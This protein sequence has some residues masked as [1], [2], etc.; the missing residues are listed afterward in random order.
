MVLERHHLCPLQMSISRHQYWIFSSLVLQGL[1]Q[2]LQQL[3]KM[4]PSF[5]AIQLG[6]DGYLIVPAAGCVQFLAQ[7][8]NPLRQ[9]QLG[10]AVNVFKSI[11]INH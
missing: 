5:A 4:I 1:N 3:N 9:G 7:Y 2:A 8:A 11:L 6:V 10:K